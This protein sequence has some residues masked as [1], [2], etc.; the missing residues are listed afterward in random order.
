VC[1]TRLIV[2]FNN[3]VTGSPVSLVFEV[4][5]DGFQGVSVL[6]DEPTLEYYTAGLTDMN[7]SIRSFKSRELRYCSSQEVRVLIGE[8]ELSF[9]GACLVFRA[10]PYISFSS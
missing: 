2:S 8:D 6:T 7:D 3:S 1:G 5:R 9:K 4:Y 10:K